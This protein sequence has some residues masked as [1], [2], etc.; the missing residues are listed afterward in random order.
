MR[1]SKK[2]HAVLILLLVL[3][4]IVSVRYMT[5]K[6][7]RDKICKMTLVLPKMTQQN[8][9]SVQEGI[10]D[11]AYQ[12]QVQFDV[13]Y[14]EKMSKNELE[15]LIKEEQKNQSVGVLLVYP[16]DYLEKTE[17]RYY[18]EEV[19]A[20]TDTMQNSFSYYAGFE[21]TK[22]ETCR[23]PVDETILEQI[24]NGKKEE[25]EL[26]NTYRLGYESVQMLAE[27]GKKNQMKPIILKPVKLDKKTLDDGSLDALFAE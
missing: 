25:I 12:H 8:L 16:E 7:D 13:W 9:S 27:H 2:K 11:Y 20:L 5:E 19:L 3:I 15:N 18:Y 10:R 6:N 24:K 22:G 4:A 21:K 1:Q 23:L 26:E 14:E 17:K